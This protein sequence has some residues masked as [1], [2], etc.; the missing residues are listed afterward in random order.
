MRKCESSFQDQFK[1]YRQIIENSASVE[2]ESASVLPEQQHQSTREAFE[3]VVL[4][5]VS[6]L[7]QFNVSKHLIYT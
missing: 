3:V 2:M 7:I 1:R 5:D 6:L 4:V